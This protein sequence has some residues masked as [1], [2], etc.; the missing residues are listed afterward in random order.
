MI[1]FLSS[2]SWRGGKIA[3]KAGWVAASRCQ[4]KCTLDEKQN[5]KQRSHFDL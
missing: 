3:V 1:H 2:A 4:S 5:E